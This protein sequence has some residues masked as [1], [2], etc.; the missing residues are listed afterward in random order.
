MCA[1]EYAEC[2]FYAHTNTLSV[3]TT[4]SATT[5]PVTAKDIARELNL[6][7]PTVSRILSGD[8][9]HR[10][11][12]T[13]RQ[14]VLET[15]QRLHYQP[16]AV[17]R[18]LR[19]GRTHLVGLYTNHDYDARNDFLGTMIG[20]LQRACETQGLDLLLH[21]A[22]RNGSPDDIYGKLRDG[23]IDGLILHASAGDPLIEILGRSSLPVVVVAD[24]LPDLPAVVCDDADGMRQLI[25]HLRGLGY[26]RFAL[27]IPSLSL[28]SVERRRAAFEDQIARA[29]VSSEEGR[30]ILIETGDPA[31]ADYEDPTLALSLLLDGGPPVAVCCWND[32]TAYNLLQ[33]C[34]ERGIRVPEQL[35]VAGFDG[36]LS[37]KAPRWRLVTVRCPWEDVAAAA[38]Q[39]L[40]C[41]VMGEEVALETCLPVTLIPGDTA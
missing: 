33:A 39:T 2:V 27:L 8:T 25:A 11:S 18:S 37:T 19:R 15:A 30:V 36:F 17:A 41:L 3:T 35:A 16:N 29:G 22:F 32:R 9:R 14:R 13:T 12:P 6:S 34:D 28:T 38:L 40:Q 21:S 26:R 20:S 23:R 7:Q 24:R 4:E 10:V 31:R 1:Y 5:V